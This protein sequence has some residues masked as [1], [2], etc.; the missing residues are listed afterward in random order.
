MVGKTSKEE[1]LL[2]KKC[3][4]GNQHAQ[5]TFYDR[6]SDKMM[7]VCYRY[8]HNRQ[9]AEDV[10]QEGF[11]KVFTSLSQFKFEGSLEG[12]VRRIMVRTAINYLN[13]NKRNRQQLDVDEVI[14]KSLDTADMGLRKQD[15]MNMLSNLPE[16]YRMVINLYAI[17]GYS[18]K[19]IGEMLHISEGTS[20]SQYS[21]G[22]KM[23]KEIQAKFEQIRLSESKESE[24]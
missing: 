21:R 5:K 18:H 11:I 14:R 3:C 13:K 23:L 9:D 16:G 10:L 6:Y 20:R 15:I 19:E 12:W 22:K 4:R 1:T 24:K 2:V 17:E 7:G 8:V